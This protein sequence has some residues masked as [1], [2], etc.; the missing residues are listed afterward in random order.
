M[1]GTFFLSPQKH[2]PSPR[3]LPFD[4][5]LGWVWIGL[6]WK[7]QHEV[8]LQK[9]VERAL[10]PVF[11]CRT[12][13]I[14]PFSPKP[15]WFKPFLV[16]DTS[17]FRGVCQV[18]CGVILFLL[19]NP[20][21]HGSQSKICVGGRSPTGGVAH[22]IARSKAAIFEVGQVIA[23]KFE[24][25][26]SQTGKAPKQFGQSSTTPRVSFSPEEV[27]VAARSRVVKLR[28][29]LTTLGDDDEASATIK[30]AL[31]KAEVQA[32]E[33]PVSEQI[34][35]TQLYIGRT[36][37]RVEQARQAVIVAREALDKVLAIQQEQEAML[38][39]GV[40]RLTELQE[41][42]RSL[43]SPFAVPE[44]T[45]PASVQAEFN[46]LQSVIEGLHK[47]LSAFRV[48]MQCTSVVSKTTTTTWWWICV[49]RNPRWAQ[50]PP[51]AITGA[52]P[53]TPP[54][55]NGDSQQFRFSGVSST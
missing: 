52:A 9:T 33:R 21:R 40:K 14:I 48:V 20:T 38:A 29:V 22:N 50:K 28:S 15:F 43:P 36:E 2:V 10:Q 19:C 37:K 12:R 39:D 11:N 27:M 41:K 3:V 53:V 32:Q 51:L 46:R 17:C 24:A 1:N 5:R 16:Q 55:F 44:P 6:V 54:V 34:K 23:R 7:I 26:S 47:E 13:L 31:Q 18:Q 30:A 49:T 4:H 8:L 42:E 35:S 25:G 45:V